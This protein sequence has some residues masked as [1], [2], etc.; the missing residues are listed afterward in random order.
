MEVEL[1]FFSVHHSLTPRE[2]CWKLRQMKQPVRKAIHGQSGIRSLESDHRLDA[3]HWSLECHPVL[4]RSRSC[5]RGRYAPDSGAFRASAAL[6]T[7]RHI[8]VSLAA[9]NNIQSCQEPAFLAGGCKPAL[10]VGTTTGYLEL[11]RRG[12]AQ[13]EVG[14]MAIRTPV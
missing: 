5:S 12:T 9:M 14:K 4:S 2:H 6:L 7:G 13:M 10:W 11:L 8:L 1:A 3:P